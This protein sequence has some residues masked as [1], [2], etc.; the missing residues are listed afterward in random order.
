MNLKKFSI[1]VILLTLL[2]VSLFAFSPKDGYYRSK[3]NDYTILVFSAGNGSSYYGVIYYNGNM[4][5]IADAD[6]NLKRTGSNMELDFIN[7]SR[8]YSIVF[9]NENN[10]RDGLTGGY[11]SWYRDAN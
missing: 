7:G 3:D 11:F 1:L 8:R 6:G 5:K 4:A 9:Y 2:T 10:F